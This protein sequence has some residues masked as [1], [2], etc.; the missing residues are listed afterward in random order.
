MALMVAAIAN[1]GKVLWP[2]LVDRIEPA[3]PH[4]DES[5][6]VFPR[7][8]V[9]DELGASPRALQLVR[10]AMLADVEDERSEER[11]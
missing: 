1:G 6:V 11:V 9:R 10:D 2:R 7:K 3:D 4:S 5:P 8:P